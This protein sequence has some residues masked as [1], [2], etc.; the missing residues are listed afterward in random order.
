MQLLMLKNAATALIP[1]TVLLFTSGPAAAE[2]IFPDKNLETVIREILKK[3]Q[4]DK[5]QIEE[6]DL[7]TI[8]FLDGKGR[9]IV[10]L[11]G[12]EKCT[13]L[14][15]ITLTENEITSV[16]PLAGLKN[17]QFLDLAGNRIEDISPLGGMV[18][19]QYI[20]L[21]RNQ[22]TQ[23][24]GLENLENLRSLYLSDNQISSLAPLSGLSRL[25]SLY[26]DRNKVSD[27]GPISSLKWLSSLGLRGNA[28]KDL[29]PLQGL[30][31]LRYTFLQGNELTD[32]TP[33]V[34]MAEKDVSGEKRFA[35]YWHLY[36]DVDS[37][38]DPARKQVDRLKELGVRVNPDS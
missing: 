12:L 17:C 5:P 20:Q 26:V 28:V 27:L 23:L 34:E 4:I 33:L 30:T 7:K 24:N 8:Y 32:L 1:L 9:G 6:A 22:I 16:A 29:S 35:P 19:L 18:K 2:D 21:E 13:N 3:K 37:L 25:T 15:S 10:D 11:T 38:P 31:E 14:A 36:L